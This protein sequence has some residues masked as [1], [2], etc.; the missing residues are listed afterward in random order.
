MGALGRHLLLIKTTQEH[1][2]SNP[3]F[4]TI[5]DEK[6]KRKRVPL[7]QET[8]QAAPKGRKKTDK[9]KQR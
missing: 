6:G 8:K 7:D 2:M 1:T 4:K 3:Q 5:I 9:E